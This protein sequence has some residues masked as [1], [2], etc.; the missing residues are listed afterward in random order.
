[1][2]V[3]LGGM[4]QW[5]CAV[6]ERVT[7]GGGGGRGACIHGAGGIGCVQLGGGWQWVCAVR[8]RVAVGVCS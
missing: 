6:R 2:C 7:G 4:R 3:Q 1:M 8:G 5:V